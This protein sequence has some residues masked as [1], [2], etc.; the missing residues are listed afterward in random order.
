MVYVTA[1][2]NWVPIDR[3]NT[4]P[5]ATFLC[6]NGSTCMPLLWPSGSLSL[7]PLPRSLYAPSPIL[8]HFMRTLANNNKHATSIRTQNT[9]Q[10]AFLLESRTIC[11]PTRSQTLYYSPFPIKCASRA[12]RMATSLS[13]CT[14]SYFF[15]PFQRPPG[16]WQPP[17]AMFVN[18]TRRSGASMTFLAWNLFFSDAYLLYLEISASGAENLRW[19]LNVEKT[20]K[21]YSYNE[22]SINGYQWISI[23]HWSQ[24]KACVILIGCL[25]IV[26]W[27]ITFLWLISTFYPICQWPNRHIS[28]IYPCLSAI[29]CFPHPLSIG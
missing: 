12:I 16:R 22:F 13:Q 20:P 9:V 17:L 5:G 15:V 25:P 3:W 18:F 26:C 11:P 19:F 6:C 21:I 1:L 14:S 2:A 29:V 8:N 4:F 23:S 28:G 10:A 24:I 27:F 7:R